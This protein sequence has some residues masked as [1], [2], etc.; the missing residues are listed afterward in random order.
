MSLVLRLLDDGLHDSVTSPCLNVPISK[1]LQLHAGSDED[2]AKA[3][4]K[5]NW[6][7]AVI[8][9]RLLEALQL[10]ADKW[11]VDSGF[12]DEMHEYFDKNPTSLKTC[13]SFTPFDD[14]TNR[15]G[16]HGMLLLFRK[17]LLEADDAVVSLNLL[18]SGTPG[19]ML[20]K[21][22]AMIEPVHSTPTT[23]HTPTATELATAFV[24]AWT[25]DD[26]ATTTPTP[27]SANVGMKAFIDAWNNDDPA[28]A[29]FKPKTPPVDSVS[30]FEDD[31]PPASPTSTST[32]APAALVSPQTEA[33]PSSTTATAALAPPTPPTP[34]PLSSST[35]TPAASLRSPVQDDDDATTLRF[36]FLRYFGMSPETPL[37]F[38]LPGFLKRPTQRSRD[39][40]R[41]LF[42]RPGRASC[43]KVRAPTRSR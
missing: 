35:P 1:L 11:G 16:P 36:E 6:K 14:P 8:L 30:N 12:A 33:S 17:E 9:P 3:D 15:L 2:I 21:G 28:I 20:T 5:S 38:K 42:R 10:F 41:T 43:H 7:A 29:R 37:A 31:S 27:E 13:V 23:P 22:L 39:P 19:R 26:Y 40:A 18:I 4:Y 32:L 25:N 34:M 24:Q